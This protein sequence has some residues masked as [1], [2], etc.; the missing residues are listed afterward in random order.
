[1]ARLLTE[2]EKDAE[3]ERLLKATAD[4]EAELQRLRRVDITHQQAPITPVAHAVAD[5]QAVALSEATTIAS[6]HAQAVTVLS[7]K[8]LVPVV[9]DL[10]SPHYSKWRGLFLLAVGKYALSDHVFSDAA[11]PDNAAWARMECTVLGWLYGTITSKLLDIVM[12]PTATARIIWVALEQQFLGNRETRALHLDA[13]FRNFA[14]GDLSVS[15]YCRKMKGMADALG[16]IGEA[17][18]D[19]TLVLAVLRGL[20]EKF[21]YMTALLKR[22]RPFP[23]FLEVRSD[24]LLEELTMAS[25]PGSTST[26]LI[27][28]SGNRGSTTGA[29]SSIGG[30]HGGAP[31]SSSSRA[32]SNSS[33]TRNNRKNNN[34]GG[35][36]NSS[37]SG[38]SFGGNNGTSSGQM[39]WP[40]FF[41]PWTGTVQVWPH[42]RPPAS[43][44]GPRP[45]APQQQTQRAQAFTVTHPSG[46][47]ATAAGAP[48]PTPTMA[49]PGL[50]GPMSLPGSWD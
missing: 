47:P 21:S 49:P 2:A 34:R 45:N 35:R 17:I 43:I 46:Y 22:Q 14:Q 4:Q 27:A 9:L 3:I 24:L 11:A 25:K 31:Q 19:R 16:D 12:T 29:G 37:S 40:S 50:W 15:D 48:T 1:M 28:S 7:I 8:S 6:L 20:N 18:Q 23:S 30:Q 44:L 13:E 42:A 36:N 26:A 39:G 41:N 32:S 5:A 33:A 38:N 10:H